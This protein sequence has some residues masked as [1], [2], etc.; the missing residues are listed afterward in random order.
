MASPR[1]ALPVAKIWRM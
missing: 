1:C